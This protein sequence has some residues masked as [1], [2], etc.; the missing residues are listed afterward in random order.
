MGINIEG[1][2]TVD[3]ERWERTDPDDPDYLTVAEGDSRFQV[4]IDHDCAATLSIDMSYGR[5][6]WLRDYLES[7][8]ASKLLHRNRVERDPDDHY[9]YGH[10]H[11]RPAPPPKMH[12]LQ[13][14]IS[15]GSAR[16]G[17]LS[18][19][20]APA[21]ADRRSATSC[22]AHPRPFA[23]IAATLLVVILATSFLLL[24]GAVRLRRSRKR[25]T[26]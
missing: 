2:G 17:A 5:W 13:S 19:P 16:P 7:I 8:G 23:F 11:S 24:R 20:R 9:A 6:S 15:R 26:L 1:L 3:P 21:P 14:K 18:S 22:S 10:V 12:Y 25:V 4:Y